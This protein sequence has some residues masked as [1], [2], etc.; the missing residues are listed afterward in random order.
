MVN[1]HPQVDTAATHRRRPQRHHRERRRAARQAARPTA[2]SSPPRPTPRC[3]PTSIASALAEAP[4]TWSRRFAQALRSSTAPTAS[5]CMRRR[6]TPTASWS[7]ATAA[8][9]SSASVRR[10]CSSPPTSPPWSRH[11]RQ[12]VYL[13]DG[14]MATIARRRLPH[15]HDSMARR[16]RPRARP[17][18]TGRPTTLREGRP[19]ALTCTRRSRAADAVAAHARGRLDERFDT[20]TSA[21]STSPPARPLRSSRVKILGC[22]TAYYA[23]L[24]GRAAHRGAGPHARHAEAASEFRYRNPVVEPDTLYIAVSQ[25]GETR[26]A[27]RG[28]GAAAQ[29]R[30]GARHRQRGR[31]DHRPAVDGGIYIHAGPE[32]SVAARRPSPTR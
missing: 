31:L 19:R 20:A 17:P 10:R 11:T 6:A 4:T 30:P 7:P 2:S 22:G 25:S 18:S 14:E 32:I 28:A 5:P 13:D 23:G 21:A 12:V 1:A 16:R 8:R 15:L 3:S 24:T 9:S 26:H 27:R 29:G